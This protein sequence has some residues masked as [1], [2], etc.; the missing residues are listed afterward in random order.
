M[1]PQ[2]PSEDSE[3]LAQSSDNVLVGFTPE[4]SC[5]GCKERCAEMA[6]SQPAR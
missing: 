4:V 2:I 6:T 3:G 5:I 1:C